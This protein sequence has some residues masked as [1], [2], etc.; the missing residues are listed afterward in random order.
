MKD[1]KMKCLL[2][3]IKLLKMFVKDIA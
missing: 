2:L 1:N 3:N